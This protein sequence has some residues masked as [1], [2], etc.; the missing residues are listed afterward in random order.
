MHTKYIQSHNP[1]KKLFD[2]FLS[3]RFRETESII[4]IAIVSYLVT[5]IIFFGQGHTLIL[6]PKLTK[7]PTLQYIMPFFYSNL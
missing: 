4:G 1:M 5:L 2:K 6:F 7:N 3:E